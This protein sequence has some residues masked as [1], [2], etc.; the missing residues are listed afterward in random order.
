MVPIRLTEDESV[1]TFEESRRQADSYKGYLKD[2]VGYL[3]FRDAPMDAI[4]IL[5][6]LSEVT[7]EIGTSLIDSTITAK[8]L[9]RLA[10]QIEAGS[11]L[12]ARA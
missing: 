9:R 3:I 8:V 2:Q 11:P 5:V 7:A 10:D 12:N 4:P 1:V 6:A